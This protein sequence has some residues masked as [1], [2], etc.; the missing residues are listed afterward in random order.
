MPGKKAQ[1]G[2]VLAVLVAGSSAPAQQGAPNAPSYCRYARAVADSEA[3]L[4]IGPELF[5]RV[6]ALD[7][8]TASGTE[9]PLG[10]PV[11]R[12]TAG[13]GFSGTNAIRA[14]L[15]RQ[16]ANAECR[17]YASGQ[18]LEG[19]L[20]AASGPGPVAALDARARLLADGVAEAER[21]LAGVREDVN[22]SRATLDELN[23]VQLKL[24]GLRAALEQ[25]RSEMARVAA[26]GVGPQGSLLDMLGEFRAADAELE[27]ADANL[28]RLAAFD[29][30]VRAG[31]DRVFDASP[32]QLPLFAMLHLSFRPGWFW[33]PAPEARA[34]EGRAAWAMERADGLGARVLRQVAELRGESASIH[35]RLS[36]VRALT[37]DLEGQLRDLQTL[38]TDRIRRF[39][40]S[41]TLELLRLRAERAWLEARDR[42]L[43][44]LVGEES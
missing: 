7:A 44:A 43:S 5:A 22:R 27:A 11:L 40:D 38:E 30:E 36:E 3:A 13:I 33:Q 25:T 31:Y 10:Q 9:V 39:R 16:R 37:A 17:R 1:W 4:L 2:C 34:E 19:A 24:E 23:A 35:R 32:Q 18:R 14:S 15:L 21:I 26:R 28:R 41:V 12:L 6:G 29:V 8:G 42:Q 20:L